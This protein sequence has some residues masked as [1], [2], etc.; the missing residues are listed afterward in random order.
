MTLHAS[1][2][3]ADRVPVISAHRGGSEIAPPG[4]HAA[5]RGAL[6]AG[7]GFLEFDVRRTADGE[8]VAFH[9]ARLRSGL[10]VAAASYAELCQA[11][12]YEV[13]TTRGIFELLAGQAGMHEA[14]AHIDLKVAAA[15]P[16]VVAQALATLEP[17]RVIV[18]S[19]DPATVRALKSR[20]P[21][22]GAGL[23]IGGD[24]AQSLRHAVRWARPARWAD[25]VADAGADWAAVQQ[26]LAMIGVLAECRDRGV[27]T[28]I[29][30][31]NRDA[32]LRKWLASLDVD[33]L[34]TDRPARAAELRSHA[35]S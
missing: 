32:R 11:V 28:L 10:P 29:W 12:G 23:T 18:T 2:G 16:L 8:L 14:G 34:V 25:A 35:G 31:V 15:G 26:R 13:P 17:P 6:A 30:T 1:A 21:E 22:V 19:R 33:V 27:R 9:G 7:A 24:A 4:T 20:H 5:Y 3:P